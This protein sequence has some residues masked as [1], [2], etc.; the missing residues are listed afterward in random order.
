MVKP[1]AQFIWLSTKII[2]FAFSH[3]VA[4]NFCHTG[5]TQWIAGA[6]VQLHAEKWS[7]PYDMVPAARHLS[8][9]SITD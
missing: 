7:R 3:V 2:K 9:Y 8:E 5:S 6:E 1:F 4:E